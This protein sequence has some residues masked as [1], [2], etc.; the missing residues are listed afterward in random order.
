[1]KD[2]IFTAYFSKGLPER[3]QGPFIEPSF[4]VRPPKKAAR[5]QK[6]NLVPGRMANPALL[7]LYLVDNELIDF[8]R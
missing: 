2:R 3:Q 5:L 8:E 7:L 4:T 1:M 6:W